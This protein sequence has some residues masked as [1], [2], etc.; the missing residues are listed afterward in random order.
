MALSVPFKKLLC[1]SWS[2]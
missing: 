1:F 2:W